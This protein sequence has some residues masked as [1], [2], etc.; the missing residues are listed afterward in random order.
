VGGFTGRELD[1]ARALGERLHNR[2]GDQ[3]PWGTIVDLRPPTEDWVSLSNGAIAPLEGT[4]R[5]GALLRLRCKATGVAC[6]IGDA[7]IAVGETVPIAIADGTSP[8]RGA[9]GFLVEQVLGS[10]QSLQIS[11]SEPATVTLGETASVIVQGARFH[12]FLEAAVGGQPA[13]FVFESPEQ[14][15]VELPALRAGVYDLVLYTEGEQVARLPEALTV[16]TLIEI[17]LRVVMRPELV[18]NLEQDRSGR[19]E[20]PRT[21]ELRPELLSYD[22]LGEFTGD[23]RLADRLQGRMSVVM[24]VARVPATRRSDGWYADGQPLL[25]GRDFEFTLSSYTLRGLLV[26]VHFTPQISTVASDSIP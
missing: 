19:D 22:I 16:E 12:P 15:V 1:E 26:D 8:E 14:S 20:S 17:R 25:T 5:I 6:R 21:N 10:T 23:D 11:T 7:V 13:T 24:V 3:A 4:Y 9:A 2:I 18:K